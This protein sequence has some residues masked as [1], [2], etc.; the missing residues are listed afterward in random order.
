VFKTKGGGTVAADV[1]G[2]LVNPSMFQIVLKD[3]TERK[4][5]EQLRED[6][7]RITRH[8]LKTP[9]L[10]LVHVPAMLLKSDSLTPRQ[11]EFVTLMR[12]AAFRM[13]RT[14]NMS[15]ALYKMEAKTYQCDRVEFDLLGTMLQLA[16]ETSPYAQSRKVSLN[17]LLDGA[18]PA[19]SARF[20]LLGEED[21]CVTM[22]ENLV[23]NAIEASPKGEAVVLDLDS[24]ARTLSVRNKGEVPLDIRER[25]FEKY[26]TA[27]KKWG[28]GLGT[29][30]ARLIASTL[31]FS[32]RL[33]SSRP[34]ETTVVIH[35]PPR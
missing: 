7:D 15:L 34:G 27:G 10:S 16:H 6:V 31:G 4:K 1:S 21:L 3:A 30:S 8:D 12:E 18:E 23:K 35:F 26:A 32:I 33:D 20:P 13:L 17:V 22:L 19:D 5:L 9:L 2:R 14:I 28:A 11:R 24:L 29:Y 25:F